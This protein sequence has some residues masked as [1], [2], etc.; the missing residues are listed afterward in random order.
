MIHKAS[1]DSAVTIMITSYCY[2]LVRTSDSFE[3]SPY[4]IHSGGGQSFEYTYR[5]YLIVF[6]WK[7]R[8]FF[9]L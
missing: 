1:S 4:L 5:L 8:F 2:D 3:A 9:L 6:G 7:I